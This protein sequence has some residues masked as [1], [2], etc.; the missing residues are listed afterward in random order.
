MCNII[1]LKY[2]ESVLGENCIFRGGRSDRRLPISFVIYLIRTKDKNILVDAG[3]DD[4]AGFPMSVFQKP[5]DVLREYGL[6]PLDVTDLVITHAH[7]DHV[8]AACHYKNAL[9]RIQKD[10]YAAA[11]KYLPEGVEVR[12][13]DEECAV[14]DGVLVKKIGGHTAG[15]S[16]VQVG[17]YVL[18]GDE[19]YYRQ[20][21]TD[22]IL[23]GATCSEERS[24]QFLETYGDGR[25]VPLLF[26]DPS[27][28][29]GRVGYE[30]IAEQK[31]PS[32]PG[33]S[34]MK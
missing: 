29:P 7:H 16:I 4:G 9:I 13:F 22:Q 21:L 3:C 6:K 17:Q 23:T 15:S 14:C 25:F 27:I 8:Q 34:A 12:L 5:S 11:K 24:R 32:C 28:L 30:V 33:A 19:C 31:S 1:A 20:C 18:C 2:G 26:H 10:E